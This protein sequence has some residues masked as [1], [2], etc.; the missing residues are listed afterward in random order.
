MRMKGY[1]G[2]FISFI[3]LLN[4]GGQSLDPQWDSHQV[5]YL[6]C[7]IDRIMDDRQ[8]QC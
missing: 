5:G 3:H 4:I 8:I 2:I 1:F 6:P 7:G